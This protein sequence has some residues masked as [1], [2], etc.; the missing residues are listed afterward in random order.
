MGQN[1]VSFTL[2]ILLKSYPFDETMSSII[3]TPELEPYTGRWVALLRGQLIAVGESG[4]AALRLAQHQWPKGKLELKFVEPAGGT[5]LP[6]SPLLEQLTPLWAEL[7]LPVYLVGGAVRDA[8]LGLTSHDLDFIVP[9]DG[10]KIAFKIADKLGLPAYVLDKE[11]DIG[12]VIWAEQHTYLD[13]ARYR[14]GDLQDDLFDRDFTFNALAL[15]AAA[16][17]TASLIDIHGG[18]TDLQNGRVRQTSPQAVK[19]DPVRGLRG[20]RMAVKYQ[21][22]IEPETLQAM[23]N[24]IHHLHQVSVERVRDELLNL[25]MTDNPAEALHLLDEW[26]MLPAVLPHIAHLKQFDQSPPHFENVFQHTLSVLRWITKLEKMVE[27]GQSDDPQLQQTLQPFWGLLQERQKTT[28]A[29]PISGRL[30]LRLA[31]LYHDVG[32]AVTQTIEEDGRIRYL[33]H[34]TAG[35]KLAQKELQKLRL[36]NEVLDQVGLIVAGHMRPFALAREAQL[37]RKAIFRFFKQCDAAGLDI[38]LLSLADH[39]ARTQTEGEN[40]QAILNT[41]HTLLTTFA[42]Q[43]H[44][45]VRPVLLLDGR[46][47]MQLGIPKGP[48]VGRLLRLLEEGQAAGEITT[49]EEAINFV[50]QARH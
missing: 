41:V 20:V 50:Q 22:T 26:E 43:Y 9:Q 40:W 46:E 24:S 35:V 8:L 27:V 19:N 42:E 48:E 1:L 32:K 14:A 12:R 13:I 15:P 44:T 10:V 21:F 25:L 45:V 33:G 7:D 39:L 4:P 11:R 5:P 18:L 34:D 28:W 30:L 2:Q 36:S 23:Q 31:A 38:C 16:G 49:K 47:M 17:T 6:L 3:A 29:G 37:S